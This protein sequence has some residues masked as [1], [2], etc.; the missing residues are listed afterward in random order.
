VAT[1]APIRVLIV[2]HETAASAELRKAV[3]KRASR[4]KPVK[5]TLV[6]PSAAPGLH[7][8]V[9]PEDHGK[10]AANTVISD[11]LPGL[12]KAAGGKIDTI[13]GDPSP[14]DAVQDAVNLHGF[15]EIIVSTLPHT[16]SRW[17]RLDLPHK[18]EGLGLPVTTVTADSATATK[19][20]VSI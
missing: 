1:E 17:L 11:A 10:D 14:L 15:D 18:L 20:A 2:A 12:E 3:R 5:F 19:S 7:R 8:V 6:V 4:K 13:V 16:V 9:D